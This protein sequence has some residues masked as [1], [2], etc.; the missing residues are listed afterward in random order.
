MS[1]QQRYAEVERNAEATRVALV[2][3]SPLSTPNTNPGANVAPLGT[4]SP[5]AGP[6]GVREGASLEPI[7]QWSNT[8][9]EWHLPPGQPLPVVLA[10]NPMTEAKF[11][12]GRFI[13][14]DRQL[15]GNGTQSCATCHIQELAFSDG[16]RR[17][18]GSTGQRLARNAQVLVNAA[19]NTT[20]AWANPTLTRIEQQIQIPMFGQSP[21]ELGIT[22]QEAVVLARFKQDR[23]YAQLF[24]HAFPNEADP[25]TFKNI[26][27][28][29]ATFVRGITSFSSPYDRFIAGDK[30]ALSES[31]QRGLT[32]FLSEK[33]ECHHCHTGFNFTQATLT[34]NSTANST[35]NSTVVDKP[36]FNTGLYNLDGQ[37]AY[38][39]D[40]QGV[41]DVT[42]DPADMGRFRPPTL[43]NV[44]LSAPYMHDGSFA[45]L[46]E[47]I[48]FYA[49][50]GRQIESGALQGDGKLS[51]LKNGLVAGFKITDAERQDLIAFLNG[52]TDVSFIT[53]PRYS[54][55]FSAHGP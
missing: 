43:R 35:A 48:G 55:P 46:D 17:S 14:Y 38:P 42:H 3:Q 50:G 28:A 12:L 40:N 8:S 21:V 29:L 51:P 54:D 44:A 19:Y 11:Q 9:F 41:K 52:L 15:S 10:D 32:L 18:T 34:T 36:F 13:F 25:V 7:E 53:N 6:P 23:R 31:A 22:G 39:P 26:V 2:R 27:Y 16:A 30:T 24:K 1:L 5:A 47:V 4:P 49:R 45:S 33:L 37:G 20:Y